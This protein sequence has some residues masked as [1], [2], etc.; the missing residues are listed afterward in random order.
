M[1]KIK[2]AM[3]ITSPRPLINTN[4]KLASIESPTETT[5]VIHHSVTISDLLDL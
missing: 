4:P 3:V 2:D 1:R 5:A